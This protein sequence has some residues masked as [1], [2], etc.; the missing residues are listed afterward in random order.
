M[1][2]SC[3]RSQPDVISQRSFAPLYDTRTETVGF[4]G[5]GGGG[6]RKGRKEGEEE[7]ERRV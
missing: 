6:E 1:H 7:R 4:I 3:E 2:C 5:G